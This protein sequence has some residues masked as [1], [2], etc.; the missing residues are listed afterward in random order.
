MKQ[1]IELL[2][3]NHKTYIELAEQLAISQGIK[4]KFLNQYKN[5][6]E[7]QKELLADSTLS[8]TAVAKVL[9]RKYLYCFNRNISVLDF[10]RTATFSYTM[11]DDCA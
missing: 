11:F 8:F 9:N 6:F 4:Q 3:T 10:A 1:L 7:Q 2:K 5:V